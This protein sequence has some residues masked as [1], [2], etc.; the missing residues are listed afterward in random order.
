MSVNKVILVGHLGRDP[1]VRRTGSGMTISTF[2][3]ATNDRRKGENGQWEDYAEWHRIVCFGKVGEFAESY[4]KKGSFV[5]VDGK[6]RTNKWQDKDGND[7]YTTEIL[8][9]DV[10]FVGS[11]QSN[12]DGDRSYGNGGTS[13]TKTRTSE[14]S[15]ADALD[16]AL[17]NDSP[18]SFEE[19]D[20]PF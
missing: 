11:R 9:N 13:Y 20:I 12:E 17:Q 2:S 4:L 1:E 10:R 15:S 19:D 5:Y 6:I 7:R 16:S 8:A 14:Q 3:I 18:P